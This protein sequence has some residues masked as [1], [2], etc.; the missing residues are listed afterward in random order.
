MCAVQIRHNAE[1][2]GD[3]FSDLYKWTEEI[4]EQDAYLSSVSTA[5]EFVNPDS[6]DEREQAVSVPARQVAPRSAK[7]WAEVEKGVETELNKLEAAEKREAERA[8]RQKIVERRFLSRTP[9]FAVGPGGTRGERADDA[10]KR[11][12]S[13]KRRSSVS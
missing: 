12:R 3:Y 1:E 6:D 5:K 7:Q 9:L 13:A 11:S 4:E 8:Q 2:I 10:G